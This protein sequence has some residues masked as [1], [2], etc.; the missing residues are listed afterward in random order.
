M[1]DVRKAIDFMLR[2][3]DAELSGTVTNAASDNGGCTRFGL[4]AKWHPALAAAGFFTPQI[5]R[6]KALLMAEDTYQKEYAPAL[7]LTALRSDAVA[8]AVLSFAVV[9]GT[10]SA[11]RLL[12]QSLDSLGCSLP[13]SAA[14]E[15][16]A[17]FAAENAAEDSALVPALVK[18]QEQRCAEIVAHD[19]SQRKWLHGWFNRADQVL[20][21][22]QTPARA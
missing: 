13:V 14:A 2:Q 1:A 12:R 6:D 11:L 9:D 3:E 18:A 17:T 20:A 15:D 4:C 22:V 10:G 8:C 19:P 7:R 16:D 5:P 21:L